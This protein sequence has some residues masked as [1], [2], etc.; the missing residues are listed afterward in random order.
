MEFVEC[1]DETF[2]SFGFQEKSLA[3]EQT[4]CL[5]FSMDLENFQEAILEKI[6][7][8]ITYKV[9]HEEKSFNLQLYSGTLE[10]DTEFIVDQGMSGVFPDGE[11][12]G[13]E[14]SK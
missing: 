2:M 3:P 8:F 13:R 12:V 4:G 1:V 14:F 5:V 9:R 6:E 11:T 7:S 10:I